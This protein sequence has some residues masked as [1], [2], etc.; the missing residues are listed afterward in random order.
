MLNEVKV[1]ETFFEII[2]F[3]VTVVDINNFELIYLNEIAKTMFNAEPGQQCFS[4]IKRTTSPCL[5]CK[6][7]VLVDDH[8][9]PNNTRATYEIFNEI[10]DRWYQCHSKIISWPDGRTVMYNLFVDIMNLKET[11]NNLAEAH[12]MLAIKNKELEA[13]AATDRLTGLYNRLKLDSVFNSA[14]RYCKRYNRPL[15]VIMLDIDKFKSIN[16]TFGHQVGDTTLKE[17]AL[18]L[19]K[20]LRQTDTVG[21]WGGEE[22]LIICPETDISQ[23]TFAAQKLRSAIAEHN[24]PTVKHITCSFGISQYQNAD[25]EDDIIKRADEALY[26]AK[27]NGRNRVEVS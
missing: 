14:L 15:V 20:N 26:A 24:F 13:I 18:I 16:D 2:P 3:G 21:R 1:F 7:S 8:D 6:R 4:A 5:D 17:L 10:D 9:L 12:A 19:G 23:A 27:R 22:F 11:Q 25:A